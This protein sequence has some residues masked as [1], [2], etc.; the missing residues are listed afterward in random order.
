M[1]S[2][3]FMTAPP[4]PGPGHGLQKID[5]NFPREHSGEKGGSVEQGAM[6]IACLRSTAFSLSRRGR[7]IRF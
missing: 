3:W 7:A 4:A 6:M 1:L 5:S 2:F